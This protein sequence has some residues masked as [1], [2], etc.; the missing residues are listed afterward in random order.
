MDGGDGHIARS[1]GR[2]RAWLLRILSTTFIDTYHKRQRAL[3]LATIAELEDWQATKHRAEAPAAV[4]SAEAQVLDRLT[5]SAVKEALQA[6]S[7]E[8]R[9]AIYLA[10][11]EGF[12][13]RE[14][15]E[16]MRTPIGTVMSRL[17]RGRQRLRELL[18][19]YV[20]ERDSVPG[21]TSGAQTDAA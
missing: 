20:R 2:D 1:R 7:D 8:S 3:L 16:L 10:D 18:V 12:A 14:I 17:H 9:L 13:Y 19:D 21:D 6:V 4:R 15:A 5:D 11:V